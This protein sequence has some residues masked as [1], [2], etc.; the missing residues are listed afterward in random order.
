MWALVFDSRV[1][2]L[3]D[4]DPEGRFHP[5]FK[6]YPCPEDT[7]RGWVAENVDGILE[8]HQYVPPPPTAEEIVSINRNAQNLKLSVAAQ[9]MAP[10]LV[11]LNLGD[12]TD[13]EVIIARQ[14]QAYYRDLKLVDLTIINPDWP[15]PPISI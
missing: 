5:D 2:D 3:T 4:I 13:E 15:T 7:Q 10:V 9:S 8:F 11:S 12:S 6:W 1:T 14:W